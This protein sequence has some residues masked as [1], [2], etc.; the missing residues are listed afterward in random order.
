MYEIDNDDNIVNE[1]KSEEYSITNEWK[2][3]KLILDK[4][5]GKVRIKFEVKWYDNN[6][7]DIMVR[8][9]KIN[10]YLK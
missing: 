4:K 6:P 10:Y 2:K 1:N 3:V 5:P 7:I 8:D 9:E